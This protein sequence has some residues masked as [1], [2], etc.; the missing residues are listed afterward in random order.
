METFKIFFA[1]N[2]NF[3]RRFDISTNAALKKLDIFLRAIHYMTKTFTLT[4]VI[5]VLKKKSPIFRKPKFSTFREILIF[6]P[7]STD[8]KRSNVFRLMNAN[9]IRRFDSSTNA[10]LNNFDICFRAIYFMTKVFT[11]TV[12]IQVLRKKNHDFFK[13]PKFVRFGTS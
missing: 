2:A 4:V 6:Q 3:L 13:N 11:L 1:Q 10:P 9:F 5:Q 12:V 8:G 7:R